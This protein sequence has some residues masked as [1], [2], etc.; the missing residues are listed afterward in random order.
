MT[1]I[2]VPS[3]PTGAAG[4][5]RTQKRHRNTVFFRLRG[6]LVSHTNMSRVLLGLLLIAVVAAAFD[7]D[8]YS[9]MD[10]SGD[11]LQRMTFPRL[12]WAK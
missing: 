2:V 3:H 11:D 7:D 9:F 8:F 5:T 12:R 1:V 10:G 6:L 4:S